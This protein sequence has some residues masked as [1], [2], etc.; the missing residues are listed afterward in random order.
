MKTHFFKTKL[1]GTQKFQTPFQAYLYSNL[2]DDQLFTFD[3]GLLIL[4]KQYNEYP[5]QFK[6]VLPF[7]GTSNEISKHLDEALKQMVESNL[8]VSEIHWSKIEKF[9]SDAKGNHR[10]S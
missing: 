1:K 8:G 4:Q 9:I 5:R 2:P 7:I 3:T 6:D 10:K